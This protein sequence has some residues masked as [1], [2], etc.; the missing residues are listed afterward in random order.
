MKKIHKDNLN[1]HV[2]FCITFY[3]L[4]FP[5]VVRH[6]NFKNSFGSAQTRF[7]FNARFALNTTCILSCIFDFQ[8]LRRWSAQS[9]TDVTQNFKLFPLITALSVNPSL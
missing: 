5:Y 9:F 3:D 8:D 7:I 2:H 4:N 6:F 1:F